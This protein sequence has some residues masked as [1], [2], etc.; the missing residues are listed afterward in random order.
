MGMASDTFG[1]SVMAGTFPFHRLRSTKRG[2]GGVNLHSPGSAVLTSEIDSTSR[3]HGDHLKR[4]AIM[5][6]AGRLPIPNRAAIGVYEELGMS[7][8]ELLKIKHLVFHVG[9]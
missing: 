6:Q 4:I 7:G 3:M 1:A 5:E 8:G 9:A 2:S